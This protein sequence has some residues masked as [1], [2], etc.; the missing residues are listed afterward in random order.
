MIDA[1]LFLYLQLIDM[2]SEKERETE[3]ED[4]MVEDTGEL[5]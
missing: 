1:H 3:K 2:Y 5:S 4:N